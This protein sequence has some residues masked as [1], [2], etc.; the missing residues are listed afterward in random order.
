MGST[1]EGS[2]RWPKQSKCAASK[3]TSRCVW[4][5]SSPA[6]HHLGLSMQNKVLMPKDL[7]TSSVN[8]S[9]ASPHPSPH[10]SEMCRNLLGFSN[11][12]PRHQNVFLKLAHGHA[13][14]KIPCQRDGKAMP[15]DGATAALHSSQA[16]GRT[17]ACVARC[18]ITKF[19]KPASCPWENYTRGF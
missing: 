10:L 13:A 17:A 12:T 15:T 2:F 5:C 4:P 8:L 16:G 19:A 6:P 9:K 3:R 11:P 14:I 18:K 7:G 1:S